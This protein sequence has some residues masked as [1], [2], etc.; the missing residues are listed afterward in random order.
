MRLQ[1]GLWLI[2][3]LEK[4]CELGERIN[5]NIYLSAICLGLYEL[6]QAH[7][8]GRPSY[9]SSLHAVCG[10]CAKIMDMRCDEYHL[11]WA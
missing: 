8:F 7:V 3:G 5:Y 6:P 1:L 9:V 4:I 10:C 2:R 11:F